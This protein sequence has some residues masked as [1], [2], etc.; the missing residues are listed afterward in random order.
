MKI[1]DIVTSNNENKELCGQC[2]GKCCKSSP[3]QYVPSDFIWEITWSLVKSLLDGWKVQM[4]HTWDVYD[5]LTWETYRNNGLYVLKPALR[6]LSGDWDFTEKAACINHSVYWCELSFRQRPFEC[7]AL[8]PNETYNCWYTKIDRI[9]IDSAWRPYQE[10]LEQVILNQPP[11]PKRLWIIKNSPNCEI[12]LCSFLFL[13][14]DF[15]PLLWER[16][17]HTL[18]RYRLTSCAESLRGCH[19]FQAYLGIF[20]W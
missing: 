8:I 5:G 12:F 1:I 10:V 18:R 16:V 3:W 11:H 13:P 6:R 15:F 17:D 9:S 4:V 7:R 14:Q 19:T 2:W 20:W